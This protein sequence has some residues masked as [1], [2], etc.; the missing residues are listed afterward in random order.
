MWSDLKKDLFDQGLFMEGT[1]EP[2]LR[3][4]EC[5]N[6]KRV[7]FPARN[8]CPECLGSD[9]SEKPLGKKGSL[10]SFTTVYIP[11]KNFSP[12]YHIGYIEMESGVRVFGQIRL[13]EDQTLRIGLPMSMSV[14]YLWQEH[15]GRKAAAYFFEPLGQ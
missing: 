9:L 4:I 15:D 11:S 10:Y 5:V 1:D 12:P 8:R 13:K 2:V 3:G 14:D 6:C 7:F